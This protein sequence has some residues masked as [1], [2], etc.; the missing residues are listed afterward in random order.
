VLAARYLLN[1]ISSTIVELVSSKLFFHAEEMLDE[2]NGNAIDDVDAAAVQTEAN[3]CGNTVANLAA[4]KLI[5]SAD[6]SSCPSAAALAAIITTLEEEYGAASICLTREELEEEAWQRYLNRCTMASSD[7]AVVAAADRESQ[8]D[9]GEGGDGAGCVGTTDL[10]TIS[11]ESPAVV[12]AFRSWVSE[13]NQTL[14]AFRN[15]V[16]TAEVP[17]D[18]EKQIAIV[19]TDPVAE[20]DVG[21]EVQ[22]VSWSNVSARTGLQIFLDTQNR[23]KYTIPGFNKP[24]VF[25]EYACEVLLSVCGVKNEK[26][27]GG[28]RNPMPP[29]PLRLHRIA[30]GVAR[31]LNED[32]NLF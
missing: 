14:D 5:A 1:L 31:V 11:P 27:K 3:E 16:E 4:D 22:L 10:K 18:L 28:D 26:V 24:R 9:P 8:L 12:E 25:A 30:M 21:Y 32:D 7:L 17:L 2:A 15:K 19:M 20:V 6:S 29:H 13:I 23:L